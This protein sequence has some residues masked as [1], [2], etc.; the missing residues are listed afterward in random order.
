MPRFQTA[1]CLA[2]ALLLTAAARPTGAEQRHQ[3]EQRSVLVE[4]EAPVVNDNRA[5]A[6]RAATLDAC[7]VA[8]WRVI[9]AYVSGED[10]ARNGRLVKSWIQVDMGGFAQVLRVL[11]QRVEDQ[12]LK[13]RA[14]VVVSAVP[15]AELLRARGVLREWRV[16]VDLP[17]QHAG[18]RVSDRTAETEFDQQLAKVGFKVVERIS[19]LGAGGRAAPEADIR[20]VGDVSSDPVG[21][22]VAGSGI[23]S[24]RARVS[25][26]AVV[27]D[28]GEVVGAGSAQGG[29]ADLS[30]PGAIRKAA[31][32]AAAMLAPRLVRDILLLPA[33]DVRTVQ[34]EITGVLDPGAAEGFERALGQAEGIRKVQRESLGG[35]RLVWDVKADAEVAYDL[36][37]L[38]WRDLRL[39]IVRSTGTRVEA[40]CV[41]PPVER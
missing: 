34:V 13:I 27:A 25:A 5:A 7:R 39:E 8:I 31:H 40:R 17:E 11:D 37:G 15:V 23:M 19:P 36:A 6:L 2:M 4:A 30:E 35:G 24:A 10:R 41:S 3:P 33:S 26:R 9:G 1:V 38:L 14:E 12:I 16:M 21:E 28:T 18:R 20:I 29:G 32:A 22:V